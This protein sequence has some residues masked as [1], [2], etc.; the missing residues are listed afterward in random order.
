MPEKWGIT[1]GLETSLICASI[2]RTWVY[3]NNILL[4]RS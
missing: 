1:K 4:L 2:E 3:K